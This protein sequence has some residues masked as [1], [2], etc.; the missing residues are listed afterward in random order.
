MAREV[1]VRDGCYETFHAIGRIPAGSQVNFMPDERK[2]DTFNRECLLV[3]YIGPD[4]SNLIGWILIA[5][6]EQ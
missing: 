2:F 3:K 5:D 1:W 6:L 4:Q